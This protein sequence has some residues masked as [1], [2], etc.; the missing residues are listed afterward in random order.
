MTETTTNTREEQAQGEEQAREK[1]FAGETQARR[2]RP[3][4]T[5]AGPPLGGAAAA[6]R[7]NRATAT[8]L[9]RPSAGPRSALG[10]PLLRARPARD[11]FP[12]RPGAC[13]ACGASRRLDP[14]ALA[15]RPPPPPPFCPAPA[16]GASVNTVLAFAFSVSR[17]AVRSRTTWV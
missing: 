11:P 3:P 1:S 14:E 15:A 10:R 7:F 12:A 6:E 2:P 9:P 16:E 8:A 5:A 4:A 17:C 13:R